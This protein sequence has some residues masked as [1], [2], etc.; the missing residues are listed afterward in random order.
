MARKTIDLPDTFCFATEYSVLYSDINAAN[1]LGAD[2]I[3]PITLE[4]QLRYI[5]HLGYENAVAFEDAGLIMVHSEVAYKS[6]TEYGDRL[7]IELATTNLSFK[8]FEF[9]YRISNLTKG[10]ETARVRTD[11]LFFDYGTKKVI[12]IPDSFKI[13]VCAELKDL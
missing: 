12:P 10:I 4:A 11:M 7:R 5:K 1:H 2:R 8:S 3:L 9:V 13:K 6:E